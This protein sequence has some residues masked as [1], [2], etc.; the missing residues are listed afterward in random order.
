MYFVR[1]YII[2]LLIIAY[3][4]V[5]FYVIL[6]TRKRVWEKNQ[7]LFERKLI[8]EITYEFLVLLYE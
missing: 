1:T 5:L 2:Y 3:I 4:F 8:V 6:I 7:F